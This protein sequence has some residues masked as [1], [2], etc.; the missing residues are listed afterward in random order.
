MN[1]M[2]SE[3]RVVLVLL[4]CL[5]MKANSIAQ[6]DS[7]I[8][9]K[10]IDSIL[11][12]GGNPA[13]FIHFH[14]SVSKVNMGQQ[15]VIGDSIKKDSTTVLSHFDS[16][17]RK[18]RGKLAVSLGLA[19]YPLANNLAFSYL[20]SEDK[21]GNAFIN[22]KMSP[23]ISI[24]Y[25]SKGYFMGSIEGWEQTG[26]TLI[27]NI[28][29]GYTMSE[30]HISISLTHMIA[31][32]TTDKYIVAPYAGLKYLYSLN[33]MTYLVYFNELD[34][35]HIP[36]KLTSWKYSYTENSNLSMLELQIGMTFMS[37]RIFADIGES[38]N[39]YGKVNGNW[40]AKDTTGNKPF[41]YLN[42]GAYSKS[43]VVFLNMD[44]KY[45]I[46]NVVFKVGYLFQ[47]RPKR[48]IKRIIY[49]DE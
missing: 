3:M 47:N 42:N 17:L 35:S 5:L 45:L 27:D 6:T 49:E 48:K 11:D 9:L 8:F 37:N 34:S 33:D 29:T 10:Q 32:K 39:M 43:L 18:R 28:Q 12:A 31:A 7:V 22:F 23:Q 13:S 44:Y 1:K 41:G 30:S 40:D 20:S 2:S 4:I 15:V 24:T 19:I 46:G 26:K 38:F 25:I 36:P 21:T 16:L 14:D